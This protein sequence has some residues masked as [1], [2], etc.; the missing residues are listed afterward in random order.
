MRSVGIFC[1][2]HPDFCSVLL[3]TTLVA[4]AFWKLI[5][6]SQFTFVETSDIIN[7]IIPWLEVQARALRSGD[8]ALWDP[9]MLAGQPLLGQLQPGVANPLTYLLLALPL[10][11]VQL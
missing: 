5:F 7:V 4:C 10:K 3:L 2:K 6:T 11:N 9:F 1:R 8:I